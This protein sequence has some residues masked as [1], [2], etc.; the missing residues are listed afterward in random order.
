MICEHCQQREASITI[1][2]VQNGGQLEQHYCDICAP[3]FH[4]FQFVEKEEPISLHQ[5]L[6]GWFNTQAN[7][8]SS[9]VAPNKKSSACPTCGFTYRQFLKVGKFG[10]ATCYET[11]HEQLPQMLPRIQAGTKHIEES[12]Q[13]EIEEW[14]QHLTALREQLKQLVAEER[15]EE[16]VTCRDEIRMLESKVNAGG[17]GSE[18]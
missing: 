15:F 9:K 14:R 1:T 7:P 5:L 11:F 17:Q 16:A 18:Y 2:K 12:E 6:S 13:L 10:C 4:P 3:Q 8:Q